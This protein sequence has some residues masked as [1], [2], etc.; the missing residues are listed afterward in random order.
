MDDPR[1][2]DPNMSPFMTRARP[3]T[4]TYQLRDGLIELVETWISFESSSR[5]RGNEHHGIRV[6]ESACVSVSNT[7]VQ[8]QTCTAYLATFRLPL[9]PLRAPGPSRFSSSSSRSPSPLFLFGVTRS[10]LL[11]IFIHGISM[12]TI[13]DMADN[14]PLGITMH[15]RQKRR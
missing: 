12:L 8:F 5:F 3:G 14:T 7:L 1:S 10:I 6:K 15:V 2:A 4:D 9:R 13:D 11:S